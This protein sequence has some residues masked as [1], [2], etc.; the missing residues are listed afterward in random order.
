MRRPQ[1]GASHT[2]DVELDHAE[3]A[4]LAAKLPPRPL[5]GPLCWPSASHGGSPVRIPVAVLTFFLQM[6]IFE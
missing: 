4:Q 5:L 1:R 2:L 3:P 6:G